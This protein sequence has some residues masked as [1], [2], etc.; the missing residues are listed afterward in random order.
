MSGVKG[1]SGRKSNYVKAK[2]GNLKDLS[3]DYLVDN[4][5]SFDQATK[6]KISLNIASKIMP[7]TQNVNQNIEEV[8]KRELDSMTEAI[9]KYRLD[10]VIKN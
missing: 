2:E 3:I 1:R 10:G 9:R 8:K 6:L 7:T 4:F 5:N